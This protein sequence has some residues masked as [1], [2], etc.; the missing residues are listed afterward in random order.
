MMMSFSSLAVKNDITSLKAEAVS[1]VKQFGGTLKPQLKK[2]LTEGGVEQAMKVCSIKAP[3]IAKNLSTKTHWQVKRVSLKARN[4]KF[5]TPDAW[6]NK[7]LMQFDERQK[8]GETAKKMAK[9][10]IVNNEFRFMKAQG[11]A[12]LCLTCHG[13]KLDEKTKKLLAQYYPDDKATGYSLGQ[14]RGAFS[15]TKKL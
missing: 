6:E 13:T 10:E 1:I 2:A 4:E 8:Q 12:P 14:I 5:A 3:E 7:V 15:L 9:A 11:V